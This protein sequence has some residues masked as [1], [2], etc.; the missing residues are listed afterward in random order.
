MLGKVTKKAKGAQ[1]MEEQEKAG[2]LTET[3]GLFRAA[4]SLLEK[5]G[6]WEPM[7]Q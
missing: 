3:E 2:H 5:E 4:H 1:T 6:G 7:D